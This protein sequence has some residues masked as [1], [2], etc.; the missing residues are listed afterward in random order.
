MAQ[1]KKSPNEQQ[2]EHLFGEQRE[3]QKTRSVT[4]CSERSASDCYVPNVPPVPQRRTRTGNTQVSGTYE[5]ERNGI[6]R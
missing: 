6:M 4:K 2:H 3:E 5:Q 1:A